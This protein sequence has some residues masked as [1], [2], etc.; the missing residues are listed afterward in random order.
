MKKIY[1]KDFIGLVLI[2]C[3]S[4]YLEGEEKHKFILDVLQNGK[5]RKQFAINYMEKVNMEDF[6]IGKNR[7]EDIYVYNFIKF[8]NQVKVIDLM[9]KYYDLYVDFKSIEKLH[10]DALTYLKSNL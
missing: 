5:V 8:R 10:K 2:S 9:K 1:P 6:I 3:M 7:K 4:Q